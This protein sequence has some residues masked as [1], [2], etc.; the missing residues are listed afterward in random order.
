MTRYASRPVRWILA[1]CALLVFKVAASSPLS[2]A[3]ILDVLK[4]RVDVEKQS[5]GIVVGVMDLKG[6]RVISHGVASRES[7][8]RVDGDSVF[9]IG[10]ITKVMTSLILLDMVAKGEVNLSDPVAQFLPPT[11]TVPSRNG[12]QIALSDL[13]N[14]TSGLPRMPGNFTPKDPANP[15]AD[16][17]TEQ[18][19]SFLSNYQLP[20]DIGS[21]AEYS[22]LGVGLLG[23]TL[24][25]K[26]GTDFETLLRAR[27]TQPLAMP[28][29]AITL[30]EA[31]R[32]RL[33]LGH[34]SNGE[35]VANWDIPTL[36]GAG[37][38]RSSVNDML[39][40]LSATMGLTPT[41]LTAAVERGRLALEAD[42]KMLL[43]WSVTKKYGSEILSKDGGTGGYCSFIGYDRAS[44][45]GV[46]VLSNS[47]TS[48][49]DVG[50]KILNRQ[51]RLLQYV[52]PKE[53]VSALDSRGY[54]HAVE[55]YET[56]KKSDADFHLREDVANE[57]G[58]AL[59]A[60]NRVPQALA[61]FQL[62]VFLYP[63][64]ANAYDSLAEAHEKSSDNASAIANYQRSLA[65]DPTN[66]HAAERLKALG[67][68]PSRQ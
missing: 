40:Y 6:Q 30:T 55:V 60:N 59:L 62:N 46:V 47:N 64:S 58:Y 15:Y 23:Q 31:M 29:T 68:T 24:A 4:T 49:I 37:A 63:K 43:G 3:E 12:R 42:P 34:T 20:R 17:T 16:Y 2:D 7:Q 35:V 61:V 26:A 1:T 50:H 28:S 48:V 57:W 5:V 51:F 33:A 32:Q 53:L 56:L 22:N 39:R 8:R 38:V 54:E 21:K 41:P 13:A 65:L 27:I 52:P 14:H 10:S 36:A 18:L 66:S 11:V 45:L 25:R 67:S 44:G 19:Y 9:E